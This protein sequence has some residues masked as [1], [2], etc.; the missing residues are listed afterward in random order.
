MANTPPQ[1]P[2]SLRAY[3]CG[4]TG[5]EIFRSVDGQRITCTPYGTPRRARNELHCGQ[6]F[7][8]QGRAEA[9]DATWR[10]LRFLFVLAV[11]IKLWCL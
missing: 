6:W 3:V 11:C 7:V 5:P 1:M 9:N 2:P 8:D 4:E 10:V